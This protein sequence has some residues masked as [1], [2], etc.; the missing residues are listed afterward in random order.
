MDLSEDQLFAVQCAKSILSDTGLRSPSDLDYSP[1]TSTRSLTPT[2]SNTSP[3]VSSF[4]S[5]PSTEPS[6]II[7][8]SNYIPPPAHHFTAN[9]I[10]RNAH[11]INR[12]TT[13]NAIVEH[14]CGA[15]VEYPETGSVMGQA[16]AHIF[17][18]SVNC[19]T[20]E[21]DNPKASFQYSLGDGHG[22]WKNVLCHL[23]RDSDGKPVKCNRISMSCKGLK[24][25]SANTDAF[26]TTHSYTHQAHISELITP[27]RAF[28]P[29]DDTAEREVFTKT[30]AFFC[31]LQ[32]HGCTFRTS[33]E[34]VDF[35]FEN[36][37]EDSIINPSDYEHDS[38]TPA[39]SSRSPTSCSGNLIMR[40][41]KYNQRLIQCEH[42]SPAD[43]AH[44]ILWNLQEFNVNYLQALLAHDIAAIAT[45]EEHAE[46][47][48]R[49]HR[50]SAGILER[51]YL[52][53]WEHDCQ[54]KFDIFVP[55]D[56]VA[57]PRIVIMCRNPHSHPPPAPIKTP[58]PLVDLFRLLLLDMD[59]ELA[60]ATPRRIL[61]DSGFM[62]GLCTALGWTSDCSPSLADLHPSLANLDHVHRL[63]YKFRRDKYPM[64]TGFQGAKLLVKKEKELPRHAHYVHCAETH[65]LPGG[66]DFRLVVCMSPL[67]SCHLLLA[68][69]VSIDTSF[70]RLHGWQEFEIE[71]WDNNHMR[72]LTGARAF[73]NSQSAQAHLVL[74]RRIFSIASEDTGISVSNTSMAVAMRL[75]MFC[76][77]L[78]KNNKTPCVYEP[79]HKLCDL[80]PYDH[81]R[82]FYRLCVIHF[83]RNLR[84]L[85]TQVSK[86]RM[87]GVIRGGGRKAEAWLKDKLQTNKFALPALYHPVSFIPEDIWC[88]CPTTTNGNEQAHHN[89]NHD[90]VH[91][92]LLGG[93]MRGRAF[94]DRAAQSID[95]HALLGI[96]TRD[97]DATHAYR[98]SRSITRQKEVVWSTFST[99]E[100]ALDE[101][102]AQQHD[103]PEL[104]A[105]VSELDT[106]PLTHDHLQEHHYFNNY[107]SDLEYALTPR[108]GIIDYLPPGDSHIAAL[109][110][111]SYEVNQNQLPISLHPSR[112]PISHFSALDGALQG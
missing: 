105:P 36:D 29:A 16:V 74:F 59:W 23:L 1:V 62:Q 24:A 97:R 66:V 32:A 85:Q 69:R 58:P 4:T 92:M 7:Q 83:K 91:L 54:S 25:C 35:N 48:A 110:S 44:L 111:D 12:Q 93:I 95:I 61:C 17:P 37:L 104:D 75:G 67:M 80:T 19:N 108:A 31:A 70:K 96:S 98:A 71:A 52:L 42:R 79:H 41:D 65:I 101:F 100:G 72:S 45:H 60:D 33:T 78:S 51:G 9:K 34:F 82:Q 63:I 102:D 55:V 76:S 53:K 40:T 88:A 99:L 20:H 89:I 15:I 49:W 38:V 107:V 30:F 22:G 77:E 18:I 14:P 56:L 90:G 109:A 57:V 84:P 87:L 46:R 94:D 47:H 21:F 50:N 103:I 10:S 106:P 86:E 43:R 68:H 6:P 39:I 8:A 2:T 64:G 27:T 26:N 112:I 5:L 13:V 73:I 28:S 11:R 81:L 3:A